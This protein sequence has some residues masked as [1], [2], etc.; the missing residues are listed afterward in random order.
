MP[1]NQPVTE[2]EPE[3]LV[4]DSRHRRLVEKEL[5]DLGV[6]PENPAPGSVEESAELG[7]TLL[8]GL[9]ELPQ[10][11]DS[12]RS[13]REQEIAELEDRFGT[14]GTFTELDA[15]LLELR[16]RFAAAFGGWVPDMGKNRHLGTAVS[17]D[18]GV[19]HQIELAGP[20]GG[21]LC[22]TSNPHTLVLPS[23]TVP[24]E[25]WTPTGTAGTGVTVGILDALPYPHPHLL[26]HVPC[27][28][29]LDPEAHG[30]VWLPWEGHGMFVADLVLRQ[31]PGA[32]LDMRAVFRG[33]SGR[34]NAWDAAKRIAA[35]AGSGVRVLNLS[36]GCRSVDGAPP[37][38]LTRA[39]QRLGRDI[40]VV[41]A[42]GNH[43]GTDIARDPFWPAAMPDVVAVG[44]TAGSGFS[45][46]LPWITCTA[47][48]TEVTAAFLSAPVSRPTRLP[49]QLDEREL[50]GTLLPD[51]DRIAAH[52]FAGEPV[53]YNGFATW[54]GTSFAAA[55][56]SGAVA[57]A[58]EP[59]TDPRHT[60]DT[61]L[62]QPAGVVRRFEY[63]PAAAV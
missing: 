31:A 1:S 44:A 21:R 19:A 15:L 37:L 48:G 53:R 13:G 22:P 5:H 41:A 51:G 33:D 50:D 14:H 4:V 27:E 26:G 40:L 23:P 24:D 43:G 2:F 3:D 49:A 18:G 35:F 6:W 60:L 63:T 20:C 9:V 36:L 16:S 57:A 34:A 55:T 58:L 28:V 25:P 7:L 30:E 39:V 29:F 56:V 52:E 11:L 61:L 54:S 59:D 42:A 46:N 10:H 12:L 8:S 17:V 32:M 45:P 47:D 38:V 62:A